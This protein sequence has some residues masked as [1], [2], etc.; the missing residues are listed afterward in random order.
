MNEWF[1]EIKGL[2]GFYLISNLGRVYS[3]K[4]KKV[5]NDVSCRGYRYITLYTH[6]GQ[7]TYSIHR[8]VAMAFIPSIKNKKLVNHI[9]E[10]KADNRVSNLEWCTQKE[11]MNHGTMPIKRRSNAD[12]MPVARLNPTTNQV[13]KEYESTKDASRD[14]FNRESFSRCA[15]GIYQ[16]HKGYKW[17]FI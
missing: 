11:N 15:R 16:T 3:N 8:L 7:K 12:K 10:N 1:K 5:L 9:N 2:K 6:K 14:G 13:I 4:T 17:K